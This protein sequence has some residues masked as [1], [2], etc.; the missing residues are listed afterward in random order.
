MA[1]R[2]RTG[3]AGRAALALLAGG[4]ALLALP[5]STVRADG[6]ADAMAAMQRGQEALDKG[7]PRAARVELMNAIKT[8]PKLAGARVLQARA[9]LMLGDGKGAQQELEQALALGSKQG[10]IRHL[11]ASAALLQ[12]RHAD[13]LAQATASDADPG[14]AAVRAR[15]EGQALRALGR[16]R[17]AGQALARAMALAPKDGLVRADFARL[18]LATGDLAAAIRAGDEALAL[19][20]RNA[21]VLVLRAML[22]RQQYGPEAARN[23]FDQALS[24]NPT[25]VPALLD[26]AATLADLGQASQ[27]LAL[28]R[29]A[30]AYAP[31]HAYAFYI[32]AV[33]AARAGQYE[34]AR[35]LIERTKGQLDAMAG[36]RLLRGVLHLEAHNATLAVRQ[37]AP[38]LERQPRNGRVRLLLARALYEDGQYAE[39]ERT[40]FPLVERGDASSYALTLGA[41]VHEALG[42]GAAAAHLLGR[43]SRWAV[44]PADVY[45]SDGQADSFAA[46]AN[47]SPTQ[48][49][50]NL[51]Y[52]RALVQGGRTEAAI[53]QARG[54]A[55]AN[56]GAPATWMALGDSLMASRRYPDA[57]FAY[58][59]SANIRFRQD[60]ALRLTD[61]W[62]R[63][64]S[65]PKAERALG[66][67]VAQNPMD[68]EGQRL[69][70]SFALGA[71][72]YDRA[73]RLLS[74]LRQRLGSEDALLMTDMARALIGLD[75]TERAL[76]YAA[77]AYRL[78]PMSAVTSDI[79][80]WTLFRAG[81]DG[82]QARELLEKA[83]SLAPR[84]A[85]V[86]W[87]LGQLY[88]ADGDKK[89]AREALSAAAKAD[90]FPHRD[91]ARAAL[92]KL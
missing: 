88:A 63:A 3:R 14:S 75:Q 28:T 87:H 41:Y 36:M 77:H 8:D 22:A 11:F 82:P 15:F 89:R 23:W 72:E 90:D 49:A 83:R 2:F 6:R 26:Y 56:P 85:L 4:L 71:G 30:L 78:L 9:L 39:A 91:E 74:L 37:L 76:P 21:E 38:L 67:F 20:P 68:V 81:R 58:E 27:A 53:S 5:A 34:A 31:G 51:L 69:V 19:A 64:G 32:Q 16:Y 73:F 70:A 45:R 54:L 55:Q 12:G 62:R 7:D 79:F 52:I 84:E 29:R 35:S 17:E 18:H 47:A 13:A 59:R 44:G 25:Y 40:I 24:V 50:P 80:G 86:Q 66:L 10:S 42:N 46:A 33:M 43:A 48:I 65:R 57:A 1:S 92:A 61:A 60:V